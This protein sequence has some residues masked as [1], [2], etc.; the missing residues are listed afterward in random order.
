MLHNLSAVATAPGSVSSV[1][2]VVKTRRARFVLKRAREN[3]VASILSRQTTKLNYRRR[4]GAAGAVEGS[5]I[6]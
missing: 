2:R 4:E 6:S 5:L 1:I 3:S